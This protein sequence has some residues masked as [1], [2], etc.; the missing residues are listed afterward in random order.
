[1]ACRVQKRISTRRKLHILRTLSNSNSAKRTSIAKST[2]LYIYKL[3]VALET[4]KREYE[5]LLATRREYLKLLNHVQEKENVK[6][7]KVM[8]G[9]FVVRVTCDEGGDKLVSILEAFDE[10]CLNVEQ[11][12]VCC[13]NGF[14]LEAIAVAE[15]KTLDPRDVTESLLKAIGFGNQSA[16]KDSAKD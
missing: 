12:K 14:S 4:V 10:M 3:K 7:E 15:D 1:M 16:E 2:V 6:V 9:T 5:N 11:A 13:E 8:A